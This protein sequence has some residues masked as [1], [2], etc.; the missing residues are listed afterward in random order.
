M[1]MRHLALLLALALPAPAQA[2]GLGVDVGAGAWLL[3]GLQADVHLRVEH[4][5]FDMLKVGVRPGLAYLHYE[6]T[7]RLAIPL[8]A[9]VKLKLAI[10]YVEALGGMY[11]IPSHVDPVRAHVAGGLGVQ[12]WKFSI[13]IEVGYLQPSINILGRVGFTFF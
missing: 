4:E 3:E 11:W 8:D 12:I 2:I 9:F 7:P 5:F 13:G 6:P 10:L 1:P